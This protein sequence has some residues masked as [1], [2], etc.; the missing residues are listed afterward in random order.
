[1]EAS[2]VQ[3]ANAFGPIC[4]GVGQDMACV[5]QDCLFLNV[6][7]PSDVTPESRHPVYKE[8]GIV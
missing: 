2:G 8:E 5:S 6:W 4:F 3:Q 7:T 1:M